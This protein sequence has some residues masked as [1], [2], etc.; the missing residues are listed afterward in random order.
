MNNLKF[1]IIAMLGLLIGG[2]V[3]AHDNF[4]YLNIT[5]GGGLHTLR[6]E[7]ILGNSKLGGGGT[8]NINYIRFFGH[9]FGLGTGLEVSYNQSRSILNGTIMSLEEDTYNGNQAFEFRMNYNDWNEIQRAIIA[10]IPL[11]FYGRLDLSDKTAFFIGAGGKLIFPFIYRYETV[12]G[13]IET[14][15]YYS[16]TN[17]E[18]FDIPHHGFRTNTNSYF[19]S[20]E[21][22]LSCAVFLDLGLNHWLSENVAFYWGLYCNYGLTNLAKSNTNDLFDIN[23][24]YI[25]VHSSNMIEKASL[26]SAGIKLGV[27]VALGAKPKSMLK[28]S[29]LLPEPGL[30]F[31]ELI[32]TTPD[33]VTPDSM[34]SKVTNM[35]ETLPD[36]EN[37]NYTNKEDLINATNAYAS[38]SDSAKNEI[39]HELR[40]KMF[41]LNVNVN[42]STIENLE[43]SLKIKRSYGFA[44]A[45]SDGHF[46]D[47][48]LEY[49]Q[50]IAGCLKMNPDSKINVIGY[51]CN[52]GTKYGNEEVGFDRAIHVR[53]YLIRYGASPDQIEMDTKT[54]QRPI[55]PNDCE[56]NRQKNRRTE[57]SLIKK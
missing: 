52:I 47:K 15:G 55:A 9:H 31:N 21:K 48:E 35:I 7:P 26:L 1:Y 57:I 18:I 3:Y 14:R 16:S 51:T 8:F 46:T 29:A 56:K 38:L 32:L 27:T 23:E 6:H 39:P 33:S 17:V 2:Q 11:G 10:E 45:S 22:M 34:V 12:D 4:N 30:T 44:F 36:W 54:T 13:N 42:K 41:N 40:E 37:F 43:Q 28:D 24:N 50:Y 20:T 25:G 53:N 5:A 19:G 49:M